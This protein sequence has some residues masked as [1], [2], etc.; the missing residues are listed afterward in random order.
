MIKKSRL[1]LGLADRKIKCIGLEIFNR[2]DH[3]KIIMTLGVKITLEECLECEGLERWDV[4]GRML[5][6]RVKLPL[7][8]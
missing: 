2:N 7:G 4:V 6:I 5:D 8:S 1:Y 3:K